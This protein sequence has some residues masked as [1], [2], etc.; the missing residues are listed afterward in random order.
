MSRQP[1]DGYVLNVVRMY[2]SLVEQLKEKRSAAMSRTAAGGAGGASLPGKPTERAA[3]VTLGEQEQRWLEAVSWAVQTTREMP[4]GTE[5][6]R[7][8]DLLFWRRTHTMQG[9]ALK[10]HISYRT[11]RR[12][13]REFLRLVEEKLNL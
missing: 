13:R 12:R 5:R 10:L 7:L 9:A 11:A 6:L 1:Y 3:L 8:I 4:N 2:P